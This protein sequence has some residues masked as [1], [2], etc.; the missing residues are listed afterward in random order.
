MKTYMLMVLLTASPEPFSV[1][2]QPLPVPRLCLITESKSTHVQ[3]QSGVRSVLYYRDH[4]EDAEGL[5]AGLDSAPS[6]SP[7]KGH[8]PYKNGVHVSVVRSLLMSQ[9]LLLAVASIIA[10]TAMATTGHPV[11]LNVIHWNGADNSF[12]SL[13][14]PFNQSGWSALQGALAAVPMIY[15]GDR[16]EKSDRRDMTHV[17]FSTMSKLR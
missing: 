3:S 4:V 1:A 2:F 16:I 6:P 9:G 10:S 8:E 13:F 17:N 5:V 14:D 7:S 12:Y 11:N 15:L